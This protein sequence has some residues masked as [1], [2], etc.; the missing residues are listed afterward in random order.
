MEITGTFKL[1]KV[2]LVKDGFDPERINDP[3]YWYNQASGC[4]EALSQTVYAD[5][6]AGRVK[7]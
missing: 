2:D 3:L 7:L 5:I 6:I 1:K 4:Y